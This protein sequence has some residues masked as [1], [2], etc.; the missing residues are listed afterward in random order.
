MVPI[1]ALALG[2]P[3][4]VYVPKAE[5]QGCSSGKRCFRPKPSQPGGQFLEHVNSVNR[6]GFIDVPCNR[7]AEGC[8]ERLPCTLGY[9]VVVDGQAI[10]DDLDEARRHAPLFS[11]TATA[12]ARFAC[13]SAPAPALLIGQ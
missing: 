9:P 13:S 7:Q 11:S 1:L 4:K 8:V 6:S 5:G 2:V 10:V 3:T 12:T